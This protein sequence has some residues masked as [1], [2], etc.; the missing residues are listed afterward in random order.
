MAGSTR[1]YHRPQR[2]RAAI[3][4][5]A[6]PANILASVPVSVLRDHLRCS[7]SGSY[8]VV[9]YGSPLEEV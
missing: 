5:R 9:R 8:L 1:P 3:C 7:G 6:Q 2:Q 4:D